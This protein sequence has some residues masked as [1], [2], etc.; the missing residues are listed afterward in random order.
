[1]FTQPRR[2]HPFFIAE[3]TYSSFLLLCVF[4]FN[5]LSASGNEASIYS[6]SFWKAL[7]ER[8]ASGDFTALLSGAGV[9]IFL[10]V[11][12]IISCIR[13]SR[14]FFSVNESV[15][16]VERKTIFKSTSRLPLAN[17]TTVNIERNVFERALGVSKVKIDINSSITADKTVF[18]FVLKSDI[19]ASFKDEL[20]LERSKSIG[21]NEA[22]RESKTPAVPVISFTTAQAVKHKLLSI[23]FAQVFM[24]A[25]VL[26]SF[27]VQA[28]D[29]MSL[30]QILGVAGNGLG[31]GVSETVSVIFVLLVIYLIPTLLSVLNYCRFTLSADENKIYI[32]RGLLKTFSY[33]FEKSRINAVIVRQ[34]LMARLFGLYSVEVAVVGLGNEKNETPQICLLADKAAAEHVLSICAPDFRI[35]EEVFS[36]SRAALFPSFF[37][38]AV[39]TALS[40]L[41]FLYK[42]SFGIAAVAACAVFGILFSVL[43]YKTKKLSYNGNIFSY[44]SGILSKKTVYV[45]YCD[46]QSISYRTNIFLKRFNAGRIRYT[47]LSGK[48]AQVQTTGWFP[49][50]HYTDAAGYTSSAEDVLI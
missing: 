36:S 48:Q 38:T 35:S 49:E 30:P 11:I 29:G 17:I 18:T 45:K 12:I 34:P 40:S 3:R 6:L 39:I 9:M 47:I 15:L 24:S 37:A 16:V 42:T 28:S 31:S 44:T 14:T 4:A 46:I 20:M 1:M 27:L 13:W 22:Q 41:V 10:I 7:F 19:A 21:E 23:P 5:G 43:G 8:L 2:N 26:A 32:T 25:T 50:E 33:A